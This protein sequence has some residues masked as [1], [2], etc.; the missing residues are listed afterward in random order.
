MADTKAPEA[1][2]GPVKFMEHMTSL[3]YEIR[4]SPVSARFDE[5]MKAGRITGHK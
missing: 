3:D 1:D 2:T 4:T 5:Q